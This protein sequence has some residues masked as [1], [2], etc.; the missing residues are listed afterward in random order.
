MK[1]RDVVGNDQP[2]EVWPKPE[3]HLF[4]CLEAGT[5]LSIHV[6]GLFE[7][8]LGNPFFKSTKTKFL[9]A[10]IPSSEIQLQRSVSNIYIL[11]LTSV[12]SGDGVT[13]YWT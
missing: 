13:R 5:K 1:P 7:A 11:F 4:N 12:R 9:P 3:G 6:I 8:M 2:D 10:Y